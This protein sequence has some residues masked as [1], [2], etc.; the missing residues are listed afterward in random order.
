MSLD[1]II[2]GRNARG[3]DISRGRGR[4]MFPGR[5][6]TFNRPGGPLRQGPLRVNAQPS[7]YKIA[8]ASSKL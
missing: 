2:R 1:N 3:R 5:G 8:K 7:P 6:G 4:G